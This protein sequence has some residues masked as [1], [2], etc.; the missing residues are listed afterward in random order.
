MSNYPFN[1]DDGDLTEADKKRLVWEHVDKRFLEIAANHFAQHIAKKKKKDP[2]L[3]LVELC[4]GYDPSEL[5][6]IVDIYTEWTWKRVIKLGK[7]D[8]TGE[9]PAGDPT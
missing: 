7:R 3:S 2:Y 8:A 5:D 6:E 9:D 4:A 1:H